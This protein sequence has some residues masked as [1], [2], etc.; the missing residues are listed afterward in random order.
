[1]LARDPAFLRF[2]LARLLGWAGAGMTLVVLPLLVLDLGGGPALAAVLVAAPAGAYLLLGLPAGAVAD[3]LPR[4]ATL[5]ACAVGAA[6]ALG[7]VPLAAARDA[8]GVGH[9][10]AAA[11]V[12]AALNV[13]ADSATFGAL[14]ALV[15]RERLAA[16]QGLL[17]TAGTLTGILAP[18][19]AGVLIGPLALAGVLWCEA[20]ALVV[21][22]VL[23]AGLRVGGGGAATSTGW[24]ETVA[25]GLRFVLTHELVR[26]LTLLGVGLSLAGGAVL[27]L[28]AVLAVTELGLTADDGRIGL[29][30]TGSAVG[31]AVAGLLVSRVQARFGPGTVATVGYGAGWLLLLALAASPG[32]ATAVAALTAY[33]CV[34]TLVIVN[35]IV[36]RAQV[37]PDDLQGRVNTTARMI[38]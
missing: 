25:E 5:V 35:G 16:A 20:A 14:P 10:A 8:L 6:L 22:A 19:V 3:R 36:A 30:A 15:G 26:P 31:S 38:A 24:R 23:Y 34:V 21:S 7:S 32:L 33:S 12:V 11:V 37:T 13:F 28:Y 4:G 18:A 27:G 2:A 17:T 9:V 1:M 29:L